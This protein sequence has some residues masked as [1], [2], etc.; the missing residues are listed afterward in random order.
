M[1]KRLLTA[2]AEI[3]GPVD[4]ENMSLFA[5]EATDN[6]IADAIAYPNHWAGFTVSSTANAQTVRV[7]PGRYFNGRMVF[8][9]DDGLDVALLPYL[10]TV[11]S[12]E[13]WVA[14]LLRGRV[15]QVAGD[16]DF[17]TSQDPETSIPVMRST[18]VME[19]QRI[20]VAVQ[21]SV[22]APAP[23]LR[24]TVADTDCCIAYVRLTT[25]GV[26]EIE[27]AESF[28]VKPLYEVERR[29]AA[30]EVNVSALFLRAQTIE[31]D[32]TNANS[33]INELRAAMLRPEIARQMRRDIAALR[34]GAN[35]PA[36]A[37]SDWYDPG[38]LYDQW[39][40]GHAQWRSRVDEGVHHPY[41]AVKEA[42]LQLV[43]EDDPRIRMSGRR[44]MPAWTETVRVSNW[45]GTATRDISQAVHT[46]VDAVRRE[47]A[48]SAIEYGP[49]I[50]IC[51]NAA[52]W[53]RY[54]PL[55]QAQQT[56]TKDGE[57]FEVIEN[58]GDYGGNPLV[59][60]HNVF[61]VRTVKK[62]D[63]T[64]V[65]WDYVTTAIGVNGSVFGQTLLIA[66]PTILTSIELDISRV[67]ADGDIHLFFC[68]TDPTG[69]P[70]VEKVLANT[71]LPRSQLTLGANKFDF[72]P[73]Y[74]T[75]GRR[76]AWF[77]VTVG[78]HQLRGSASNAFSG[79]TSFR[80]TD[81]VWAQGDLEFDFNFRLYGAKFTNSR[82]VINFA[83][84]SLENGLSELK[85]L[86]ANWRPEG[87]AIEWE[88]RTSDALPWSRLEAVAD[89]P[90]NGLPSFVNLRCTMLA[91]PELA[92]MIVL[93]A[94]AVSRTARVAPEMRAVSKAIDLGLTTTTIQTLTTI[95]DFDAAVQAFSPRIMVGTSQTLIAPDI[96]TTTVDPDKPGRREV[97]STYAVPAGTSVV[98]NAPGLT[99]TNVVQTAF[100]EN[101]ALFAL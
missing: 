93:D 79:G 43:T 75:P 74:L 77:A 62:V 76:Y 101:T 85:L 14:L 66:Q 60:G 100:L 97:L 70:L 25:S 53:S 99:T 48:R 42:Q 4:L 38:L 17:E 95:D 91:T 16:R 61:A 5:K 40:T 50:H 82:T 47:V 19:V 92:P 1:S 96:S 87:T 31:T 26:Q 59:T 71:T 65:Y 67:G 57:T 29:V 9:E 63:W 12:D 51:E 7:S 86:Y 28:R 72:Q 11:V 84:V 54:S 18:P 89:N 3:L 24:P 52:E 41:A 69:A 49:T 34:Q 27:P 36:G 90:L 21:Q 2:E 30:V 35:V 23:A 98:R 45:G 78:N 56:F 37:R 33:A 39:D 68:E 32:L 46:Q 44:M 81:G 13:H 10:P 83:P 80:I 6:L 22:K 58:L 8:A 64:E 88:I 55:L 73:T 94:F 15:E 20:E